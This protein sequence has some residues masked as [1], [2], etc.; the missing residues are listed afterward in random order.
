[1]IFHFPRWDM[2]VPW[3]VLLAV[4][5]IFHSKSN[6]LKL[7]DGRLWPQRRIW[8]DAWGV[9]VIHWG[10]GWR[11]GKMKGI[12]I[13]L[14]PLK[15]TIPGIHQWHG[16][17]LCG[18]FEL[19]CYLLFVFKCTD[20]MDYANRLEYCTMIMISRHRYVW[21]RNQS[22]QVSLTLFKK[23][24]RWA[25]PDDSVSVSQSRSFFEDFWW[26]DLK[27]RKTLEWWHFC[28]N[29]ELV[30]MAI[31]GRD[32]PHFCHFNWAM[33]KNKTNPQEFFLQLSELLKSFPN[34]RITCQDVKS[35]QKN[36]LEC[37]GVWK[38]WEKSGAFRDV[39]KVIMVPSCYH[40]DLR[41]TVDFTRNFGQHVSPL[42][43]L[44]F[45][46]KFLRW[47]EIINI[48]NKSWT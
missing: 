47:F 14:R 23:K 12:L 30:P 4:Q 34:P 10:W 41:C 38:T 19:L 18:L 2:L 48:F 3:R 15:K 46:L 6:E 9:G 40:S 28:W 44:E 16:G 17:I 1:M 43:L 45:E 42:S 5:C 11:G 7:L 20:C 35:L 27:P 36:T 24:N 29:L 37:L 31:C 26:V 33:N 22:H 21:E 8:G 13:Y 39:G 32:L 25:S